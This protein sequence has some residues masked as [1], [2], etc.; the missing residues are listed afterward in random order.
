MILIPI[1]VLMDIPTNYIVLF[2]EV[3]VKAKSVII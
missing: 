1:I 2:E 3:D